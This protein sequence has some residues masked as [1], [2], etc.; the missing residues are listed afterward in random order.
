MP[1]SAPTV[2]IDEVPFW[3]IP[4]FPALLISSATCKFP[5]VS[6][7]PFTV[8]AACT[9]LVVVCTI[10]KYPTLFGAPYCAAGFNMLTYGVEPLPLCGITPVVEEVPFPPIPKIPPPPPIKPPP[11]PPPKL[12]GAPPAVVPSV[13]L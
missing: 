10:V 8:N 7:F 13:P 4:T 6:V 11:P 12:P 1:P 5:T 3:H 9:E 2:K